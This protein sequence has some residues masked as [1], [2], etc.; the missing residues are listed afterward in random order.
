MKGASITVVTD[1]E[2]YCQTVVQEFSQLTDIYQSAFGNDLFVDY[3]PQ[4]YGSSYFDRLWK[5]GQKTQRF[6]IKFAKK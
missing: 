2:G 1:D 4:D 6:F 3:L 5:N